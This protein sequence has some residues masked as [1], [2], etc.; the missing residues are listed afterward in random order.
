LFRLGDG[1]CLGVGGRTV[2]DSDD[3]GLGGD[4]VRARAGAGGRGGS[5]G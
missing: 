4:L 5:R 2:V 1:L 3:D